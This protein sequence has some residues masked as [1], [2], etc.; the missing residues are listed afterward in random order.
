MSK[1]TAGALNAANEIIGFI[2]G[3]DEAVDELAEIIERRTGLPALLEVADL[4]LGFID[5][6]R[7]AKIAYDDG[8][9]SYHSDLIRRLRVVIANAMS[10]E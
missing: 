8:D 6:G 5:N 4:V 7:Q 3:P 9:Q 2:D 10:F 1:H